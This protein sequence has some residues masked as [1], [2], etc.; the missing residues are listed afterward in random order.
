M[1]WDMVLNLPFELGELWFLSGDSSFS[2]PLVTSAFLM[3]VI[4]KIMFWFPATFYG[5]HINLYQRTGF[6]MGV[7]NFLH[8]YAQL[9][10]FQ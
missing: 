2:L 1:P 9:K 8:L 7:E 4:L 5:I 3:L 10:N 6:E